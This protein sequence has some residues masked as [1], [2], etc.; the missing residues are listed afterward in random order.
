MIKT[1]WLN[2]GALDKDM[3]LTGRQQILKTLSS[4]DVEVRATFNY[5]NNYEN[6]FNGIGKIYLFKIGGIF[7]SLRLMLKQQLILLKNLDVDVIILRAWK[8]HETFPLFIILRY[9]LRKKIPRFIL[10]LRTVPVDTKKTISHRINSIRFKS[11]IKLSIK[12]FDGLT[13]ISEKLKQDIIRDYHCSNKHI[14]VWTTGVDPDHF[15]PE[16]AGD[17]RDELN[18]KNRFVLMYH[19]VFSPYRGLQQAIRAID[20]L[21]EKYPDIYLVLLGKGDAKEEFESLVEKLGLHDNVLIHPPIQFN[22]VPSFIN[23]ADCGIL[24]FPDLEWWNTSGPL[25][26]NEY[27]AIGKPV[28]LTDIAAHRSVIGNEPFGFYSLNEQPE[29][30][31]KAIESAYEQKNIETLS[32]KARM[33]ALKELTWKRQAQKIKLYLKGVINEK[34]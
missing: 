10:D 19:G 9:I 27:L 5:L 33:F 28:I 21:K 12:Y 11:S 30:L 34:F 22:K 23:S 13:V 2:I 8:I 14:K 25:K 6:L 29:Y 16:T 18:I 20:L 15:N 17:M 32:Q 1:F 7:S 4:E 31:A 3:D 24:P 26:L